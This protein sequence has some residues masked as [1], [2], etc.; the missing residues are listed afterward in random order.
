MVLWEFFS[1]DVE[2]VE[3]VCA[4]GA[5]FE[6]GFFRFGEF[7]AGFV[8]AKAVATTADSGGLDSEDKVVVVLAV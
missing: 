4:V 2:G 6:E 1:S 5:V 8:F 3:G 7:F